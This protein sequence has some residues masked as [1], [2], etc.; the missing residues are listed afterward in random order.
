MLR[1]YF[2]FFRLPQ[3]IGIKERNPLAPASFDGRI[4]GRAG[5]PM[6]IA[7]HGVPDTRMP[8]QEFFDHWNRTIRGAVVRNDD[9]LGRASLPDDAFER[10]DYEGLRIKRGTNYGDGRHI[11]S[12]IRSAAWPSVR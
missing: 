3:I 6:N 9:L 10:A 8:V 4:A 5:T 2:E 12:A 1:N 11:M 7:D